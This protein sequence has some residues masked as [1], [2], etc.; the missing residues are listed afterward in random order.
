MQK[1]LHLE[2]DKKQGESSM[3]L[4]GA[5]VACLVLASVKRKEYHETSTCFSRRPP[6]FSF[7]EFG[8]FLH[9]GKF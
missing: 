5:A 2:L 7:M 3:P 9:P 6:L 1:I 4:V 8:S